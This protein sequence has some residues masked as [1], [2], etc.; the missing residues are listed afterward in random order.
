MIENTQHMNKLTGSQAELL[1]YLNNNYVDLASERV[2]VKALACSDDFFAA[3]GNLLKAGR[4]VF[5]DDKY[6]DRGKW[7]DGWESR[8]SY[9]RGF[10]I[11]SGIDYDWCAIQ[12]G[13]SGCIKGFDIDTNFF[14]GNAP[15][16][17]AVEA[18]NSG[19][20]PNGQ[21]KWISLY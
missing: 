3:M 21:T 11:E 19:V 18:C 17:V 12:L 5:I 16:F 4:G 2:G 13:M 15:Q 9:G 8:R 20:T 1:E 7:M 6:T 10:R 14:R